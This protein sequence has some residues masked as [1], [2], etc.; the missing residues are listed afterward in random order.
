[1]GGT[2]T[3]PWR[4]LAGKQEIRIL[5]LGLD[6]AG[7]TT[8]LH[9]LN[10][11][12]VVTVIPTIG[13][14]VETVEYKNIHIVV[15]DVGGADRNR[16]LWRYYYENTH[17]VVFVVDS[18]DR[19]RI[20]DAHGELDKMLAES[21]LRNAV[22]LIY[23]N[24]QDLPGVM[25]VREVSERMGLNTMSTRTCHIQGSCATTGEGL[26]DGFDWLSSTL[27]KRYVVPRNLPV[28]PT[29]TDQPGEYM[30]R[31]ASLFVYRELKDVP[32]EGHWVN[33]RDASSVHVVEVGRN[34]ANE[35][36]GRIEEPVTGWIKLTTSNM[37]LGDLVVML[38]A[39]EHS[40]R[41]VTVSGTTTAGTELISFELAHLERQTLGNLHLEI[42]DRVGIEWE[43]LQLVLP[44]G[45][46]HSQCD[47]NKLAVVALGVWTEEEAQSRCA[48]SGAPSMPSANKNNTLYKCLIS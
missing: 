36:L 22:L 47:H 17:A 15:W 7:K 24:K 20:E 14:N 23:A 39:S 13:F 27:S 1:M 26:N 46:H 37:Q 40:H 25:S 10:L 34:R 48:E 19:D 16:P 5:M 11:A 43:R 12:E 8:I 32:G 9:K 41:C 18:N 42:T 21:A 35:T 6:A 31:V 45:E 4:R 2:S 3:K 38:H 30:L 44:G 33:L 29:I 28:R